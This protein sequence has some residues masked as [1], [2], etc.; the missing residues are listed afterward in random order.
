MIEVQDDE[1]E[2]NEHIKMYEEN[3]NNLQHE[4]KED[5]NENGDKIYCVSISLVFIILENFIKNKTQHNTNVI[6]VAI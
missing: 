4:N 3:E 5:E 6:G 1:E 2:E